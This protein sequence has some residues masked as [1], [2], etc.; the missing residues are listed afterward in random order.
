MAEEFRR[1][2]ALL[3]DPEW[4]SG[5]LWKMEGYTNDEIA[6]KAGRSVRTVESKVRLIRDIWQK[7]SD[8]E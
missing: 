4:R 3:R 7:E 1:L 2:L 8:R 5:A 6:L